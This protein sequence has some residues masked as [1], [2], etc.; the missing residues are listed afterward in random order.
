MINRIL[1]GFPPRRLCVKFFSKFLFS[2]VPHDGPFLLCEAGCYATALA[3]PPEAA[4]R[5]P[6]AGGL[7]SFGRGRSCNMRAFFPDAGHATSRPARILCLDMPSVRQCR[8]IFFFTAKKKS[9]LRRDAAANVLNGSWISLPPLGRWRRIRHSCGKTPVCDGT[10]RFLR[11]MAAKPPHAVSR[12]KTGGA[13][14]KSNRSVSVA[15]KDP[16]FSR[17]WSKGPVR[18]ARKDVPAM[19]PEARAMTCP[20]YGNSA[21]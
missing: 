20:G 14:E 13:I 8:Q 5:W 1:R 9:G 12:G 15:G 10:E 18:E 4:R 19:D 3:F 16:R 6:E 17:C 2:Q 7:P 11:D 21:E